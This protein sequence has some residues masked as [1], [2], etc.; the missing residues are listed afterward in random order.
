MKKLITT[1]LLGSMFVSLAFSGGNAAKP[2]SDESGQPLVFQ[3]TGPAGNE[4]T[5][6]KQVNL[7]STDVSEAKKKNLKVALLMHTSADFTNSVI[8]G[9]KDTV[10]S[11]GG[12]VVLVTDAGFDSNKQK[13]DIENALTLNADIIIS[14]ILDPVSGAAA[15]QPAVDR[16]V[17]IALLSNLPKDFVH[18]RDYAAIVTDDL[19]NMGKSAAELMDMQLSGSGK[20][21]LIYHDADYYVTNQRDRSVKTILK[22]NFPS[23]EIVVEQGIANPSD[24]EVIASAMLTRFPSLDA[25]YAP[26]DTIAE[27]VLAAARANNKKDLK[28]FTMDLGA[29]TVLDMAKSGNMSGIVADLPY[30]LGATL[31]RA[32]VL[33][34]LGKTPPPFITVPAIKVTRENLKQAWMQSLRRELPIEVKNALK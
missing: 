24:G 31:T 33:K 28:V 9:V 21:G 3:T 14:L 16:G 23:L 5:D 13:T 6:Y 11:I 12:E 17:S 19:F 25:I 10:A 20:V 32:A 2:A 18:G 29:T 22:Q 7:S 30:E 1:V 34:I 15:L 27:G 4:P 8:A 26:W